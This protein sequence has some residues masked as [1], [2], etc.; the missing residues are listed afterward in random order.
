MNEPV[1]RLTPE[2]ETLRELYLKSG[3]LCM[4]PE[5]SERMINKDGVFIGQV[6]HI[7]AAEDGG[8]RFNASQTNEERRHFS[9][10]MLMCYPHHTISNDVKVYTVEKLKDFKAAHETRFTD[11]AGTIERSVV[12]DLTKTLK[13]T[14]PQRLKKFSESAQWPSLSDDEMASAVRELETWIMKLARLSADTRRVFLY[15]IERMDGRQ[16]VPYREIKQIV[17][18][19]PEE[20]AEQIGTLDR[21]NFIHEGSPDEFGNQIRVTNLSSGWP[22]VSELKAFAEAENLP[23]EL[24]IVRL[25]FSALD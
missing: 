25:D 9:N 13:P 5:C 17:S 19:P 6:C 18:I 4:F 8:E 16:H 22:L 15:I 14:V 2:K 21:Y 11:I 23:L 12:L 1:K 10:L 7:E 24:M 3:N 20:L